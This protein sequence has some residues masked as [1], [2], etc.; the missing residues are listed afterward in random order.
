M[1]QPEWSPCISSPLNVE[2][3]CDH[4]AKA[5]R[6]AKKDGVEVKKRSVI[7]EEEEGDEDEEKHEMQVREGW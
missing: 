3:L 2:I 1:T 5:E 7:E 4:H 6:N